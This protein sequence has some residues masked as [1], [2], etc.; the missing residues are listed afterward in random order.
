MRA[1][2]YCRVSTD[3]Q[4]N[5]G[6]SL[7]TQLEACLKYCQDK[8]YEVD[9]RFSEAYSGLTLERP[10][11]SELRELVRNE[12]I[13]VM[14]V[15][16][17]DR[18]SRD[19]THGVILTQELEKHSVKLE[20]V[21]EDIDSSELGKL[22]S[23]IRGF[24]SKLEA[25]K[26]K[27]R[28]V[29]GR[30]ARAKE[31][32]V[33]GSFSRTYGYDYI[34]V[35]QKNGGRRIIN[36]AEAQW[37]RQMFHW[38]VD[39]GMSTSAIRDKLVA[40]NVPTKTGNIWRRSTIVGT[41]KNPG[42]YGKTYAFTTEKGKVRGK[43]QKDWTELPNVTPPIISKEL[44]DTAQR[45]L[46]VN[47]EKSVRNRK[48][49][50]LL[51]GHVRCR[52][53]GHAYCGDT[54]GKKL[55]DGTY[56]RVYRCSMKWRSKSPLCR[57]RNRNW[58]ADNLEAIVW[59]E[60]ERYLS[61]GELIVKELEKQHQEANQLGVYKTQLKDVQ[62]QLKAVD[63]EQHQLLQ[64]ALKGFPEIQVEAENRRINKAREAL[65]ARKTELETQ[66]KASHEAAISIP[67]LEHTVELLRQQLKDPDFQTKRD[68]I[69]SMGITVWLDGE[70]VEIT[71]FIPTEESAIVTT[72]S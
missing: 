2:I 14:V 1:A 7:Q 3:N 55:P 44:F 24:A 22:I 62:Q 70:N 29:R 72:Q 9:Y 57:C 8:G 38:L 46:Q 31:G 19:P 68:F 6:T 40:L 47:R 13:D 32:R 34:P 10:K 33:P 69:E 39:D 4:E 61:N 36:E 45:Q 56:T 23:Y 54:L 16:A 37:V 65:Q 5:E 52:Q 35:S 49:Q 43:P 17:L 58:R 71:G 18:L 11:L 15:Y 26:I 66:F 59:A 48:R 30:I 20:A 60:L 41:L 27:E 25:E 53:C 42:Y 64:W 67:R 21:T 50:Y 12:K 63:R 28:T 51:S